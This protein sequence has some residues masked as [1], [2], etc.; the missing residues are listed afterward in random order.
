MN[1][2]VGSRIRLLRKNQYKGQKDLA[3]KLGM[4]ISA[5][6]KIEKGHTNIKLS[7]LK[8]LATCFDVKPEELI[9]EKP[10]VLLDEISNLKSQL[11][12]ERNYCL[13][14]QRKLIEIY[15]QLQQAKEKGA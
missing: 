8:Q 9:G 10:N 7:R 14:L 5:Y 11:D 13:D 12:K 1:S 6:S 15:D 3:D 2:I 4:T